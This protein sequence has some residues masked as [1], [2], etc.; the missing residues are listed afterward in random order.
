[1]GN[2]IFLLGYQ[3]K[4]GGT[5]G[6]TKCF[7]NQLNLYIMRVTSHLSIDASPHTKSNPSSGWIF[8]DYTRVFIGVAEGSC[9]LRRFFR[10]QKFGHFCSLQANSLRDAE[11]SN[12]P[13]SAKK[14][15][16]IHKNQHVACG[17]IKRVFYLSICRRREKG[18]TKFRR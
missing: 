11:N 7:A 4:S 6:G 16:Y 17:L 13:K 10:S 18:I 14:N 15:E 3:I 8:F 12:W 2:S 1:M 5:D 9:G